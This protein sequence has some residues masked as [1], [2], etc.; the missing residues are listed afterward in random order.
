MSPF[1]LHPPPS[2]INP[3]S[4]LNLVREK[5]SPQ[6][7]LLLFYHK[8]V[9]IA[10]A[11]WYRFPANRMKVIAITGTKGK[12]TTTHMLASILRAAGHK[13]GVAS[14]ISFQIGDDVWA[15]ET[16]QTTQGRFELQRLLREM[17]N[18]RCEYAILEVTSHAL[19]Q[20]RFWGINVDT[21]VLTNLQRDHL[22]YHGGF[23]NYMR[24]KGLLFANLGRSE[25]KFGLQKTAILPSAEPHLAYFESFTADRQILYGIDKGMIHASDIKLAADSSTFMLKVPNN[26]IEV[27]LKIPGDF[28]VHN[29]LAACAAAI[30]FGINLQT[31]KKGLEAEI[32]IPGRLETIQAG[33]P[34]TVVV[35][36][37]HTVESLDKLLGLFK[38]LT[39]GKLFLVFGATGGGRDKAKRPKMG[40]VADKYVDY[41][42]VTDDDSYSE[43]RMQIIEEV[44]AGIKRKE[45]EGFWKI[46]DRKQA[47]KLA[48]SRAQEG[49]SVLIAGKGC[50]SVH[51]L[52]GQRLEWDDRK[53][54]R[55]ILSSKLQV[56][57]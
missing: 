18:A 38:P 54:V 14:T 57:L 20:S 11:I 3:M 9:A 42:V 48:L 13:I 7:S 25:R 15:N 28:N 27:N 19:V 46:R 36:Y 52:D 49:D 40:E 55:E 22:E 47:I 51:M 35:D 1:P 16:K 50:E 45:G 29:S 41:I 6:N 32:E 31:I 39:K 56:Q 4:L 2:I 8:L 23:E 5:I 34:F 53:V 37:A 21:A 10:A 33:Q 30:S 24:A 26:E 43:D 44:S 17:A 12:S